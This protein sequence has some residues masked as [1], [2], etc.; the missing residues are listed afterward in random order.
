LR[1]DGKSRVDIAL[2]AIVLLVAVISLF[3][4]IDRPF[5]FRHSWNEAHFS[6]VA[7]SF[8]ITG[9]LL[10]PLSHFNYVDPAQMPLLSWLVA[11]SFYLS[12]VSEYAAR[13]PSALATLI[14][15]ILV[16]S[17]ARHLRGKLESVLITLVY[18]TLPMVSYFGGL[19]QQEPLANLFY[20]AYLL[21]FLELT[22]HGS[23]R[24]MLLSGFFA[25][26]SIATKQIYVVD[27]AITLLLSMLL[28]EV[29]SLRGKRL[30]KI[31]VFLV[32]AIVTSVAWPLYASVR[33][34]DYF[35]LQWSSYVSRPL[36]ENL[37]QN[38]AFWYRIF[39][40]YIYGFGA[41]G[42]LALLGLW[43]RGVG[44]RRIDIIDV[45]AFSSGLATLARILTFPT[46]AYGHEY[47][48]F[49]L[50]LPVALL[51]GNVLAETIDA[52]RAFSLR[53]GLDMSSR[54][55]S[56]FCV[57]P[58]EPLAYAT[59]FVCLLMLS[60]SVV[61][62]RSFSAYYSPQEYYSYVIGTHLRKCTA[63]DSWILVPNPVV[64]FYSQRRAYSWGLV[65]GDVVVYSLPS[66]THT[67]AQYVS[68]FT[69]TNFDAVVTQRGLFDL[70][71]QHPAFWK[72]FV[73]RYINI[74]GG[75]VTSPAYEVWLRMNPMFKG[76]SLLDVGKVRT[77][78]L[79][80]GNDT[81][82]QVSRTEAVYRIS[83]LDMQISSTAKPWIIFSVGGTK[84]AQFSIEVLYSDGTSDSSDVW[85][86]GWAQSPSV[87]TT[88]LR[89]LSQGKIL[90][91]VALHIKSIDSLEAMNYWR[92]ILSGPIDNFENGEKSRNS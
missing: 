37:L 67:D 51:S 47:Y 77:G 3:H 62:A 24:Y 92:L 80:A 59:F 81:I 4:G 15:S 52:A 31:L 26:L 73:E 36:E 54:R 9:D 82:T 40:Y 78:S 8:I 2:M 27:V 44:K 65:E 89:P 71:S 45:W 23:S 70:T 17:M 18:V 57:M 60:N 10:T 75:R 63:P 83:L 13:L 39:A 91:S 28:C 50:A 42:I 35:L 90:D 34:G 48:M 55:R 22:I 33:W 74:L 61:Y 7:Q 12:G 21:A 72:F 11:L 85:G 79:V 43:F 32:P 29:D 25:G 19:V 49:G 14:S 87:L 66:V 69:S 86:D 64:T 20:L 56:G 68:L 6:T 1:F 46:I 58:R 88:Y 41:W 76:L 16:L 30:M 53:I 84:N 5:I 38:W